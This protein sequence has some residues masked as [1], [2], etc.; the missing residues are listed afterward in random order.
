MTTDNQ[1]IYADIDMSYYEEKGID[2][3]Q[4]YANNHIPSE[5]RQGH[6]VHRRE[7]SWDYSRIEEWDEYI[8]T[9]IER[10][11]IDTNIQVRKDAAYKGYWNV[12][13]SVMET[14]E[15]VIM[16]ALDNEGYPI[17]ALD[18]YQTDGMTTTLSDG[19]FETFDVA[20]NKP[21]GPGEVMN[22]NS[23]VIKGD[24]T[25]PNKIEQMKRKSM[26][27][28]LEIMFP[29]DAVASYMR[30]AVEQ[31][32]L[33][34]HIKFKEAYDT[35]ESVTRLHQKMDMFIRAMVPY[36]GSTEAQFEARND[37]SDSRKMLDRNNTKKPDNMH[38]RNVAAIDVFLQDKPE[39]MVALFLWQ[40]HLNDYILDLKN[41]V[42]SEMI[43]GGN[44]QEIVKELPA[45]D[46]VALIEGGNSEAKHFGG[47]FSGK[48]IPN[49]DRGNKMIPVTGPNS[50][51]FFAP[52]VSAVMGALLEESDITHENAAERDVNPAAYPAAMEKLSKSGM[53]QRGHKTG[54]DGDKPVLMRCPFQNKL[55]EMLLLDLGT[56]GKS[57]DQLFARLVSKVREDLTAPK[58]E[59]NITKHL[60]SY[61]KDVHK[62]RMWGYEKYVG[63]AKTGA[64]SK[65]GLKIA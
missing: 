24:G 63:R 13:E 17:G 50:F 57:E 1:N 22:I 4:W 26:V 28:G 35:H 58:D 31:P 21:K 16:G 38:Q 2:T 54:T 20:V 9:E 46:T 40:Q 56:Q 5:H 34:R 25:H 53:F 27:D 32:A 64:R 23:R 44:A 30:Y 47:M 43:E 55:G 42:R 59:R 65:V 11:I 36:E 45:W 41:Y 6:Y 33:D 14:V 51:M 60:A 39:Y 3:K 10:A 49:I 19:L 7:N 15:S 8:P 18:K 12:P 62:K 37:S 48:K 52:V 29:A 61:L